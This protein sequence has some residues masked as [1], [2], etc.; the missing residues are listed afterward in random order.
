MSVESFI[1]SGLIKYQ[2]APGLLLEILWFRYVAGDYAVFNY[3]W[4]LDLSNFFVTFAVFIFLLTQFLCVCQILPLPP[5]ERITSVMSV[6]E[7]AEDQYLVM[8]TSAGYIKRTALSFFSAIRPTGIV[9]I[10]LVSSILSECLMVFC[11]V[12]SPYNNCSFHAVVQE[13]QFTL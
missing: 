4:Y 6:D 3:D 12:E 1:R 5:G 7:F 8:L 2:N 10:Q 9:A 11:V 13:V